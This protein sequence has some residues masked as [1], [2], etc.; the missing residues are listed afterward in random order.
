LAQDAG[1][2]VRDERAAQ[3][4]AVF[5]TG[6]PYV[7]QSLRR[8]GVRERDVEDVTQEVFLAV[9]PRLGDYDP[10]RP[11]RRWLFGFARRMASDY[12]KRASV[13]REVL[14]D[15]QEPRDQG[16]AA[17][18]R[19]GDHAQRRLL[20]RALDALDQRSRETFVMY[21]LDD[22]PTPEIAAELG[23]SEDAVTSRLRR[24]VEKVTAEVQRLQRKAA[25]R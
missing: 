5:R 24:A 19:L 8:L 11:L 22:T 2:G 7:L 21:Y 9:Y 4:Q 20:L 13:Q 1:P 3:F 18:E 23:D 17:D 6:L 10:S 12:R 25:P 15:A 14:D 16:A